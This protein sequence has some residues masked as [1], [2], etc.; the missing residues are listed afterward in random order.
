MPWS[1]FQPTFFIGAMQGE[2]ECRNKEHALALKKYAYDRQF[3]ERQISL[4]QRYV[5]PKLSLDNLIRWGTKFDDKRIIFE[6]NLKLIEL[7]NIEIKQTT[8]DSLIELVKFDFELAISRI[9]DLQIDARSKFIL[10]LSVFQYFQEHDLVC[11][12]A[13]NILKLIHLVK[14]D[15]VLSKIIAQSNDVFPFFM[16]WYSN[17]ISLEILYEDKTKFLHRL[18][19]FAKWWME[20]HLA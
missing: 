3:W 11:Q 12:N 19:N 8:Q 10:I 6:A 4:T 2:T 5:L 18:E 9:Q 1:L 7:A 15:E 17:K 16:G 20:H 14:N 13:N